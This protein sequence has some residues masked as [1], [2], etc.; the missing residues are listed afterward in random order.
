[1]RIIECAIKNGIKTK[2]KKQE[3]GIAPKW[4]QIRF[5]LFSF[6]VFFFFLEFF[7]F[8]HFLGNRESGKVSFEGRP[9]AFGG[10]FVNGVKM[11]SLFARQNKNK[12]T[13]HRCSHST[14]EYE[15]IMSAM[16]FFV[17]FVYNVH[18]GW[19]E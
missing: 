16:K 2:N 18:V 3:D 8:A 7:L 15:T 12:V 13:L 6:L 1:M 19:A 5:K 14:I 9:F 17:N 11:L 10:K 4:F